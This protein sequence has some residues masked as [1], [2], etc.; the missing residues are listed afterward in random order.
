MITASQTSKVARSPVEEALVHAYRTIVRNLVS[1][2]EEAFTATTEK[3]RKVKATT[4]SLAHSQEDVAEQISAVMDDLNIRA[5]LPNYPPEYTGYN[6][7]SY[8]AALPRLLEDLAQRHA[9]LSKSRNG[10]IEWIRQAQDACALVTAAK[11]VHEKA[12]EKLNAET[13]GICRP[14][15]V[16]PDSPEIAPL[17]PRVEVVD[18]VQQVAAPAPA[19][20][21]AQGDGHGHDGH[22]D[23][24]SHDA[25]A[26]LAAHAAPAHATPAHAPAKAEPAPAAKAEPAPAAKAPEPVVEA[27]KQDDEAAFVP[28]WTVGPLA[29]LDPAKSNFLLASETSDAGQLT[30]LAKDAFHLVR[31]NVVV[32]TATP[33]AVV[34]G[35][36]GD[37]NVHVRRAARK[38][39]G[40]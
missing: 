38:R 6:F 1:Y 37:P 3:D 15:S 16:A 33:P 10:L 34:E 40:R 12:I 28:T 18:L 4:D 7:M 23:H 19:A 2:A 25:H 35:L 32:N 8:S 29:K 31:H 21:P 9:A 11:I 20:A 17:V 27:P 14:V 24:A 22:D 39:L 26:A 5:A 36:C 13:A 30:K